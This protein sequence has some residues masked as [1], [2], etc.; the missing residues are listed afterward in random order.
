MSDSNG[1]RVASE[2]PDIAIVG[3]LNPD[4][5]VYGAPQELPEEREI[6]TSGFTLTLG[7]SSAI[8][9]HNL[10]LL[11]SNTGLRRSHRF[12]GLDCREFEEPHAQYLLA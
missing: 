3:E 1:D 5:I 8:L 4:L 9:A 11:G 7:S 6:L 2:Q 10:S 12:D